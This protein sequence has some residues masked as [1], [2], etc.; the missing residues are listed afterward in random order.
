M[1]K[2]IADEK[3]NDEKIRHMILD[4]TT[5][6][7]PAEDY[8]EFISRWEKVCHTE[9]FEEFVKKWIKEHHEK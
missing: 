8:E 7:P 1:Y 5:Y 9:D 3:N 6:I 4:D 2:K